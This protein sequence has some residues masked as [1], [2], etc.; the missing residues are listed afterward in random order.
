M[1]KLLWII[2]ALFVVGIVLR[3]F[4][5][6]KQKTED[7]GKITV[8]VEYIVAGK[9]DVLKTSEVIGTIAADK[10]AQVFPET[11]GRVTKIMA[12][13]G[14][15]V[16]KGD[17]ILAIK[18][19][20]VGFEFEEAYVTSPISGAIARI[21]VDVGSMV[22]PQ[23]PV[24]LVV[25]YSRVKVV[26]NAP[27]SD[28]AGFTRN[29]MVSV[30]TDALP[31]QKFSG[32]ITEVSPVI[33]PMTRTISI[34]AA[35]DNPRH[36]LKPGMTARIHV[37]MEEKKNVVAIPS[38]ALIDGN[39]FIVKNDSTAEKRSVT[40]GLAG[41]TLIE[42]TSGLDAS[43]WVIIMGQQRLAGSEKV[44]PVPR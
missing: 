8:A 9:T 17:R 14:S 36:A 30:V 25:D 42:I 13:D 24:A 39:V 20:T 12:L 28:A 41:D 40:T 33:D 38:D 34:K 1:K 10:T 22:T 43:E 15:A 3:V 11:M 37:T 31:G 29:K 2:I 6:K 35:I 44:S 5:F 32:R 4:V 27:E 7:K 16:A 21:L 18:N 26:F 19:E 23:A